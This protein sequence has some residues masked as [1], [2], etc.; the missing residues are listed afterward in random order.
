M[1]PRLFL[2][3]VFLLAIGATKAGIIQLKNVKQMRTPTLLVSLDGFRADKLDEYLREYPNSTLQ[4]EFVEKGVKAD[5]MRPQFPTLTFP[6]HHSI[7]TGKQIQNHDIVGNSVFDPDYNEYVNLLRGTSKLDVKWWNTTEPIWLTAKKQG[8]KTA[9]FFWAGSEVWTRHPDFFYLYNDDYLFQQRCD[10]VTNWFKKFKMDFSTLYFDEPDHTGHEFGPD[11]PQYREKVI[12]VDQTL[13]YL[14][15]KLT[16][17]NVIDNMNIIVLSD[18]GMTQMMNGSDSTIGLNEHLSLSLI[19][20]TRTVYGP[21]AL[22]HPR[23]DTVKA[24]LFDALS[25]IPNMK[26]YYRENLPPEL[27]FTASRRIAPIVAIADEGYWITG[28]KNYSA[29]T[30]NGNHGFPNQLESMRAIFL[31]RGPDFKKNV[32]MGS[33]ENTDVYSL[34]CRLINIQCHESDGSI[35]PFLPILETSTTTAAPTT[36]VAT[37]APQPGKPTTTTSGSSRVGVSWA[38]STVLGLVLLKIFQ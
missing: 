35:N 8:L 32:K 12:L 4:R 20:S 14:I 1:S 15:Q 33:F 3:T 10:E 11:S 18:H 24:Q 38:M 22:I 2:L 36:T 29:K 6:N 23:N 28:T 31:A 17:A 5:Y 7:I 16:D 9:S 19:N 37:S 30:L 13:G 34:L 26:V 27:N 25:K 21:T